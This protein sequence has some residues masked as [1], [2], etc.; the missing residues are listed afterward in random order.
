M[1]DE[2]D[3]LKREGTSFMSGES[4][5]TSPT[6]F[7]ESPSNGNDEE[8]R[9]D[10]EDLFDENPLSPETSLV[11]DKSHIHSDIIRSRVT[12]KAQSTWNDLET[13]QG[14]DEE[15]TVRGHDQEPISGERSTSKLF[16]VIRFGTPDFLSPLR[17]DSAR[18]YKK[19][20]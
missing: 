2:D 7:K 14:R 11:A 3:R 1:I 6:S 5:L 20:D 18:E 17:R 12:P 16:N 19:I 8:E 10:G 9:F 13:P 15:E 4:S